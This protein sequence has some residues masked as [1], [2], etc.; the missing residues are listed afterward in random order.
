MSDKPTVVIDTN[1]LLDWLVFDDPRVRPLAE[2]ILRGDVV[3]IACPAMR[4]ELA[5]MLSHHSLQ[6][7]SPD[8]E[9]ALA[10]FD[11]AVLQRPNPAAI[12]PAALRCTDI[13]DQVFIDLALAEG[14]SQLFTRDR[15]L[16]RLARKA[17]GLGLEI[18]TPD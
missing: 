5:H 12:A 2:Q 4:E 16:L 1:V 17:R 13:D 18:Q 8:G 9:R 6:R 3:W 11:S 15:A 14:A 7:W 10:V